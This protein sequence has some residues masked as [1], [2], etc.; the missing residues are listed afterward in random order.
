[1][2]SSPQWLIT[3]TATLPEVGHGKER[4]TFEFTVAQA[5]R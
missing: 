4:E 5:A 3:I 2:T 1:M